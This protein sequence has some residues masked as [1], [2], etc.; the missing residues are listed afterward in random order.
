MNEKKVYLKTL[1]VHEG[2]FSSEKA[3]RLRDCN[4]R[5]TSGFF[6]NRYIKDGKLEVVV[7][8]EFSEGEN[9]V[10]VK[11]PGRTIEVPG[12]KGYLWVKKEDLE[13]TN[14]LA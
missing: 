13:Y 1:E 6:E 12:D 8:S 2:Q 11:L 14:K 5:E 7:S 9:C 4:G 10:L 3:L